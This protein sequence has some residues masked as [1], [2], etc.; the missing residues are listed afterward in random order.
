MEV[1]KTIEGEWKAQGAPRS[2]VEKTAAKIKCDHGDVKSD[3]SF[4]ND[5]FTMNVKGN[6]VDAKDYPSTAELKLECKPAKKEYKGKLLFDISTPD[7]SGIKFYDNVSSH[8][9]SQSIKIQL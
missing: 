4:C 1:S 9:T 7:I 3:W 5:K 8:S 6:P 2:E